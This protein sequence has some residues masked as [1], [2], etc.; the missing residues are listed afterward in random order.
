MKW[1]NAIKDYKH[2]LKIERGLSLN[3]IESYIRD[4]QKLIQHLELH[5]ISISPIEIDKSIIQNLYI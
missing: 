5:N 1:Q 4:V 2:Y 3:S